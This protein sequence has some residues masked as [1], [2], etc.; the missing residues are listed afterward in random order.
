MRHEADRRLQGQADVEATKVARGEGNRHERHF[1][2]RESQRGDARGGEGAQ[3]ARRRLQRSD[4]HE[5]LGTGWFSGAEQLSISGGVRPE[6]LPVPSAEGGAGC[7]LGTGWFSGAEQLNRGV[8]PEK[9]PVP[10]A[11]G[12]AHCLWGQATFPIE[13]WKRAQRWSALPLGTGNFSSRALEETQRMERSASGIQAPFP[14]GRWKRAQR[15]SALPLG[16]GNFSSR[17]LEEGTGDGA[18]PLDTG[19][20]QLFRSSAGRG[21]RDGALCLW[22]QATFPVERW[23]RL[24]AVRRRKSSQSPPAVNALDPPPLARPLEL[25]VP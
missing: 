19:C 1:R 17:A 16:T 21:H 15:W 4:A 14:V 24:R 20:E 3:Q 6:K 10:S 22:V 8:R 12:W 2:R 25:S 18:L 23:K 7:L 11:E 9:L 13:R 5:R